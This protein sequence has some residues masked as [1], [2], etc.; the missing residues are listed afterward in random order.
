MLARSGFEKRCFEVRLML[1][2][3]QIGKREEIGAGT[4][5]RL[6]LPSRTASCSQLLMRRSLTRFRTP[7]TA[8]GAAGSSRP[9]AHDRSEEQKR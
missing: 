1:A 2:D 8:S 9:C 6:L 5:T 7:G 3:Q 4:L